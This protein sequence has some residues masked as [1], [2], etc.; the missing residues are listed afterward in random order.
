MLIANEIDLTA[1][2][3][4]E[5]VSEIPNGISTRPRERKPTKVVID[6][7]GHEMSAREYADFLARGTLGAHLY[8]DEAG[9]ISQL[10]DLWQEQVARVRA[11]DAEAVWIVLQNEGRP[12]SDRRVRRGAFRYRFGDLEL[13]T[14]TCNADQIEALE[15][16]V[17]LICLSMGIPPSLP[18]RHGEVVREPLSEETVQRWEGLLLASHLPRTPPTVAPGP[19]ILDVLDQLETELVREDPLEEWEDTDFDSDA[20][21]PDIDEDFDEAFPDPD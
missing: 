18:R 21:A 16:V 11:V 4:F 2:T 5:V 3:E 1:G 7:S 14:L 15:D 8:I 9:T 6:W 12:P 10:A 13:S 19:H 20:E 17:T